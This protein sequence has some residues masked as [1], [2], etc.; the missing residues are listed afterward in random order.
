MFLPTCRPTDDYSFLP[1]LLAYLIIGQTNGTEPRRQS[2]VTCIV[3]SI[4]IVIAMLWFGRVQEATAIQWQ[5]RDR[6]LDIIGILVAVG[7]VLERRLVLAIRVVVVVV[8]AAAVAYIITVACM[9]VVVI[10]MLFII[11]VV[12]VL[13]CVFC[14]WFDDSLFHLIFCV[15]IFLHSLAATA[16]NRATDMVVDV[17][18]ARRAGIGVLLLLRLVCLGVIIVITG[19]GRKDI[20]RGH[21][22]RFIAATDSLFLVGVTM[23]GKI[24]HIR[25]LYSDSGRSVVWVDQMREI[26]FSQDL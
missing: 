16:L 20:F 15:I 5:A 24:H 10:V 14:F 18:G 8:A 12:V 4:T 2:H 9:D 19:T 11:I 1:S 22:G 7:I 21:G 17:A 25:M 3:S 26:L 23:L 6:N 13:F